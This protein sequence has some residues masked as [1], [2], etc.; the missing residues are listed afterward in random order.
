MPTAKIIRQIFVIGWEEF[1]V[2]ELEEKPNVADV[3]ASQIALAWVLNKS[4]I[5]AP[6]VGSTKMEHLDQSIAA[7]DIKL[8]E[9]EIK[10]LEESYKPH[11]VLGH[12]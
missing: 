2:I 3:T 6:I 12:S 8:T 10:R 4:Y 1:L 11:P 5:T 9:E 7:L